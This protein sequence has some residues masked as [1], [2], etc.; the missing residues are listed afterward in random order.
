MVFKLEEYLEKAKS[1]ELLNELAINVLCLKV[2]EML[3]DEENVTRV[4]A[5]VTLVGDVH[6]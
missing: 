5:P 2:K 1:G 6:G 4:A 3:I